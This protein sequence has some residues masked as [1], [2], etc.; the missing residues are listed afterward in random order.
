VLDTEQ[1]FHRIVLI[2]VY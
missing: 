1:N 2:L